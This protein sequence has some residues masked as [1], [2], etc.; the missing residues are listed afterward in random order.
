MNT[1]YIRTCAR[2]CASFTLCCLLLA[3]LA[4]AQSP[5]INWDLDDA[6]RQLDRQADDF[7]TAMS[8]VEVLRTSA[9]GEEVMR[10]TGNF[11][12]NERGDVDF[13]HY[14]YRH[15]HLLTHL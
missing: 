3:P 11:F 15:D 4:L 1:R 9:A 5:Q 13:I 7:D 14:C 12:I 8:R 2:R 10:E 6:L